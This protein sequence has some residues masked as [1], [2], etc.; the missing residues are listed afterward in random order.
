MDRCLREIEESLVSRAVESE[1]SASMANRSGRQEETGDRSRESRREADGHID[2]FV[3][4]PVGRR[5]PTTAAGPPERHRIASASPTPA[6]RQQ[7]GATAPFPGAGRGPPAR[8]KGSSLVRSVLASRPLSW[9]SWVLRS[10][11]P[12]SRCRT[13]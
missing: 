10:N 2:D 7:G 1:V 12:L 5:S 6:R 9:S 3:S 11:L 8:G 4:S 13:L